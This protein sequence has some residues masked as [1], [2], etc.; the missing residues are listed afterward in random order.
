[1]PNMNLRN[2][3]K[4]SDYRSYQRL[5]KWK[6]RQ[7]NVSKNRRPRSY[8]DYLDKKNYL[9][10]EKKNGKMQCTYKGHVNP[11]AVQQCRC[12]S[13]D[14]TIDGNLIVQ[15]TLNIKKN[16]HVEGKLA[17]KGDI[18][19]NGK[20]LNSEIH[21]NSNSEIHLNSNNGEI[22]TANIRIGHPSKM[23]HL[24]QFDMDKSV[25]FKQDGGNY[26]NIIAKTCHVT[27][28]IR[29]KKNIVPIRNSKELLDHYNPVYWNWKDNK[30]KSAGLIAQEVQ[31]ISPE[32]VFGNCDSG[33]S[34]NYN[35][36]IG[37]LLAR[38]KEMGQEL[39]DLKNK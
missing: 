19:I 12:P 22:N 30:Q 29:L 39:A 21:L 26:L 35:Y 5:K 18:S 33:F 13:D 27:S 17:V 1:M 4:Y 36:F 3:Q 31:K 9:C 6:T 16:A 20:S 11:A 10:C 37:I 15:K 32:A 8:Q 25:H 2:I 34:L 38:I 23:D 24:I 14:M 28:D 7:Y